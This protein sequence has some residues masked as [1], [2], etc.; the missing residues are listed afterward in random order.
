MRSVQRHR[1]G[2]LGDRQRHRPAR[3]R[4]PEKLDRKGTTFVGLGVV[5]RRTR[6]SRR[7]GAGGDR[8]RGKS[9]QEGTSALHAAPD[10][11]IADAGKTG[12]ASRR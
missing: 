1:H 7:A 12:S 4:V 11:V 10:R 8:T 6:R 5:R 3:D 2:P 9:L